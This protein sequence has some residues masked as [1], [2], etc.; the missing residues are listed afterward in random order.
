MLLVL[1]GWACKKFTAHLLFVPTKC[2]CWLQARR[3]H[4]Q[5]LTKLVPSML[6]WSTTL[7][8]KQEHKVCV[9]YSAAAGS[10]GIMLRLIQTVKPVAYT[11][12]FNIY[13]LFRASLACM[14]CHIDV[15]I[16]CHWCK[17]Q[18]ACMEV[19][20]DV[21]QSIQLPHTK[22]CSSLFL[23]ALGTVV[24]TLT[25]AWHDCIDAVFI[26]CMPDCAANNAG[27]NV[28]AFL[29]MDSQKD[30]TSP[31]HCKSALPA[32]CKLQFTSLIPRP[33]SSST[34]I[35]PFLLGLLKHEFDGRAV[36]GQKPIWLVHHCWLTIFATCPGQCQA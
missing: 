5:L 11:A 17:R 2:V 8:S 14:W 19:M 15:E 31:G 12:S 22:R 9:C 27:V 18:C 35:Q 6:F 34:C 29:L 21:C 1:G 20:S 32:S 13:I 33:T 7:M 4:T 3:A 10:T 24:M 28:A 23:Q 30:S 16:D 36:S 26:W 25:A